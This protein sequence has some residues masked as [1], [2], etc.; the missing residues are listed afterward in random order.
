M[1][2]KNNTN[3]TAIVQLYERKLKSEQ[4]RFYLHYTINGKQTRESLKEIPLVHKS[5]K[6]NYKEAKAK[7]EA[8]KWQ[9]T[10]EIRNNKLGI[11]N[12]KSNIL[13]SDW[14]QYCAN[15]AQK[16]EHSNA[17][18][19][20][21]KRTLE[22]TKTLLIDYAGNNIKLSNINKEF[23]IGFIEYLL[24]YKIDRY[25]PNSGKH[26]KA[27]TAQQKYNCLRYVLNEAVRKEIIPFNPCNLISKSEKIKTKTINNVR[28][29]LTEEELKRLNETETK[30]FE[31]KR[32]YFFMCFCGLRI[33]DVKALRW[34]N[35][36][37]NNG[38]ISLRIIQ[39]KTQNYIIIPLSEKA[40]EYLP[41]QNKKSNDSFIFSN[42]PTEPAMNRALKIWVKKAGINKTITLHTARH[43][44]AT[45]M[46]T[47]G[48][49]L[50]TTSKL[51]G[52]S[53]V[54][55]TQIYARIID[56]KKEEAVETLNN[57]F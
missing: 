16:T 7:A 24:N 20:T 6:L 32:V 41:E 40:Q 36:E 48:V 44:F 52:H 2:K 23:I 21:W 42:L 10:T 8:Y 4:I 30:S 43:T 11:S 34:E 19:H 14:I 33:S 26:Y 46:L 5:D 31:T 1:S 47:K 45:L 55:T 12:S 3:E 38:K 9:R 39:Q 15:E 50:Y 56:K 57:I 49:D 29:Y 37:K 28:E 22:H 54:G 51:L 27:T 13:L 35:I 25:L 17:N 53:E 18:R